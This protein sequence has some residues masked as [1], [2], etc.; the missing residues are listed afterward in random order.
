[1]IQVIKVTLNS[2]KNGEI[3]VRSCKSEVGSCEL[4]NKIFNKIFT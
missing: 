1:M 4:V 2:Q 3:E